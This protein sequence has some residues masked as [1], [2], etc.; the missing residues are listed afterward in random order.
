MTSIFNTNDASND[1]KRAHLEISELRTESE[2]LRGAIKSLK[3]HI[4]DNTYEKR[5]EQRINE[6]REQVLRLTEDKPHP[7]V[8][9]MDWEY[10][11]TADEGKESK[12]G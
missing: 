11:D 6:L 5:L 7:P 12:D 10:M 9:D 1:L 8:D 2:R 4:S 3:D